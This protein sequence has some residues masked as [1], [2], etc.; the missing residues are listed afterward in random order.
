MNFLKI[1]ISDL[2]PASYNPRKNLK[3]HDTEYKKIKKSIEE[4]GYV[5]PIIINS[6]NTVIGGHQRL[7]VLQELGYSEVDVVQINLDKTKE[8]ALNVALN[9]ITGD[10]DFVKLHDVLMSL[11]DITSTGFEDWEVKSILNINT[12]FKPEEEWV[13]MPE[14]TNSNKMGIKQLIVHFANLDDYE[15]FKK[16]IKQDITDKTK[17]IWFPP[18]PKA[19]TL[20]WHYE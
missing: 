7:K 11:E 16:L 13:G 19:D 10:W 14:Y 15:D 18:Q 5:E 2:L 12:D 17:F 1:K 4:F 6:D 8:K 20:E 9:K 3:E